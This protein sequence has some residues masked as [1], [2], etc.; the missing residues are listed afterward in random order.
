[1]VRRGRLVSRASDWGDRCSRI[2]VSS[3]GQPGHSHTRP[4]A[5]LKLL[6]GLGDDGDITGGFNSALVILVLQ[7]AVE[8]VRRKLEVSLL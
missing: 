7:E 8:D 6:K 2:P 3:V 5:S 4:T 1:M